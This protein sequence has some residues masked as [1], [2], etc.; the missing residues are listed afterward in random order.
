MGESSIVHWFIGAVAMIATLLIWVPVF[1]VF[2][3]I[4]GACLLLV[5]YL[6]FGLGAPWW[7]ALPI[8]VAGLTMIVLFFVRR[9]IK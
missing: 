9:R 4:F 6:L 2:A 7:M 3:P 8:A 1:G 5:A